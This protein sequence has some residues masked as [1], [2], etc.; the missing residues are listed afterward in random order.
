MAAATM[1]VVCSAAL[2]QP[3]R[4]N[5][6]RA[7]LG[8][9]RRSFRSLPI[10][11][12]SSS[13]LRLS[14]RR[15]SPVVVSAQPNLK[16]LWADF[17]NNL[18]KLGLNLQNTIA[19]YNNQ[20]FADRRKT[21]AFIVS[22]D[23]LKVFNLEDLRAK[24]E[25]YC[26]KLERDFEFGSIELLQLVGKLRKKPEQAR[27]VIQVGIVIGGADGNFDKK[28]KKIVKEACNAAGINPAEFEL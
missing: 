24:Y 1:M 20:E 19:K 12:V 4:V 15:R 21:A 2:T 10:K 11:P 17:K 8:D 3:T 26:D 5:A 27:A 14:S 13:P 22:N 9:G 16:G 28:E 7:T 18:P 25:A 6:T 23:A